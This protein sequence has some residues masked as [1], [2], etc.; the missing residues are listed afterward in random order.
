MSKGGIL[1]VQQVNLIHPDTFS[2]SERAVR[3]R[4]ASGNRLTIPVPH[5]CGLM[6]PRTG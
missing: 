1:A 4:G 5:A 2:N 6:Q 3:D